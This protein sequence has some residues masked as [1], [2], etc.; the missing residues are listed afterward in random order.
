M[1][2]SEPKSWESTHFRNNHITHSHYFMLCCAGIHL[3]HNPQS[4]YSVCVIK[5]LTTPNYPVTAV[6]LQCSATE[7]ILL[8]VAVHAVQSFLTTHTPLE[9]EMHY[10]HSIVPAQYSFHVNSSYELT[11]VYLSQITSMVKK[12]WL[13]T[14]MMRKSRL[15]DDKIQLFQWTE[16]K[17]IDFLSFS[18]QILL[19]IFTASK[20]TQK[21]RGA[22]HTNY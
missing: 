15:I 6:K 10:W 21:E 17:H 7:R 9:M 12:A 14:F 5:G 18:F 1:R 19:P 13:C 8:N 20:E 2:N 22:T 3:R 4:I 16:P 11:N